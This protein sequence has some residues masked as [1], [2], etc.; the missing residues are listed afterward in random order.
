MI[1][2]YVSLLRGDEISKMKTTATLKK[3]MN[4]H[5]S[6]TT[7]PQQFGVAPTSSN[8]LVAAEIE[9]EVPFNAQN[10][11]ESDNLFVTQ[12]EDPILATFTASLLEKNKENIAA[13]PRSFID[14][15]ENAVRI[16]WDDGNASQRPSKH[17]QNEDLLPQASD[18]SED[19]AFQPA[20]A[21]R[22]G[23]RRHTAPV[24]K[25]R[26]AH[27]DAEK[28]RGK[29]AKVRSKDQTHIAPSAAQDEIQETSPDESP[30]HGQPE[31]EPAAS[32]ANDS[33]DESEHVI[34]LTQASMMAKA[35]AYRA[36]Q[37]APPQ[38]PSARVPWSERD[39]ETLMRLVGEHNCSWSI[40]QRSGRW[41]W[42]RDQVALKDKARNLKVLLL[43]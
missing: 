41:D 15:Q 8:L 11:S 5:R 25:R 6:Q 22:D 14:R 2:I 32:Q 12:D 16:Q 27:E 3:I 24:S 13:K 34:N 39:T 43:K 7:N 35:R 9:P 1:L 26:V 38:M 4:M 30:S 36:S 42:E 19:D 37:D 20:A 31:Q 23:S 33:E 40:I 18:S 21:I 28:A 10:A 17:P 29:R